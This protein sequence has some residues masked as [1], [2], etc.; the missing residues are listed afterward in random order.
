MIHRPPLSQRNL[1]STIMTKLVT[2]WGW[3]SRVEFD[4]EKEFES[5]VVRL[6]EDL[7]GPRRIYLDC[8]RRIGPKDGRQNI[9]DAYLLDL[10]R[11]RD[12]QLFVVENELA[13]HDLFRHIGV[14]LLQFSVSFPEAG[15]RVR[16]VL[17]EE[18]SQQ[19]AILEHCAGYAK[20]A[21]LCNIDH[22]L[23]HLVFDAPFRAL[24]IIDE[25]TDELHTVVGNLSFPVEVIELAAYENTDGERIYRFS[26]FLT[27]VE[28]SIAAP[29]RDPAELDTV[30]VPARE[31]GFK[32]VFLG[33]DR[34]YAVRMHASMISQIQYVATYRVSPVSAITHYATVQ[35]IERWRDTDKVVINFKEPALEIGPIEL[36]R[37]GR[38]KALQN[39]RYTT[40]DRLLKAKSLDEAF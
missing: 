6:A 8:K 19:P 24:V 29:G 33:E 40:L 39:L 5:A 17:F 32:D 3:V 7:F 30:V 2:P 26:P 31:E 1:T 20:E 34:W 12:P 28:A 4:S 21:G 38:V 15:R 9:P 23:D 10:S 37:R 11:S 16:E 27:D 25:A 35:S 18:I 36:V 13:A 22:F 14:Q